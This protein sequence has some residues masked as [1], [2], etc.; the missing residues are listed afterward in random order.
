CHSA[1]GML[2]RL[3]G[4]FAKLGE[5]RR[6]GN[7][8]IMRQRNMSSSNKI[9]RVLSD[10]VRQHLLWVKSGHQRAFRQ[11][12]LYL[13]KRLSPT[14]GG[15][16]LNREVLTLHIAKFAQ[17]PT[18]GVK[19]GDIFKRGYG[20]QHTDARQFSARLRPRHQRPCRRAAKQRDQFAPFHWLGP[21]A[22][23][24]RIAQH[25]CPAGF[26]LGRCPLWVQSRH[27]P[28]SAQC[29]LYPRKRTWF[30]TAVMSASGKCWMIFRK[31]V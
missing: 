6:A 17:P 29:P 18:E 11:C 26:Q 4:L 2:S 20:L 19:V 31:L 28:M 15:A 22:P 3:A 23:N 5:T 24:K 27:Q 16:I 1:G 21:R 7:Q 9:G 8:S 30:S 13:Q 25:C 10:N 14:I 12:P